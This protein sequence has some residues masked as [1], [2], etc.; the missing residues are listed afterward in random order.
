MYL[1]EEKKTHTEH[2]VLQ[3]RYTQLYN[4]ILNE[5]IG[6]IGIDNIIKSFSD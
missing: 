5:Y 1:D 3:N 6:V 2:T 4:I